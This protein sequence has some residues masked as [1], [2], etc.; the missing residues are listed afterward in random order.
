MSCHIQRVAKGR[1]S[2]CLLVLVCSIGSS[3]S[4]N[5]SLGEDNDVEVS[6]PDMLGV[7]WS[8]VFIPV[9]VPSLTALEVSSI[10]T[11]V[12]FS[13][14]VLQA[15][16]IAITPNTLV[17]P[18]VFTVNTTVSG[19]LEVGVARPDDFL[20]QGTLFYMTFY[21][22]GRPAATTTI[23]FECFMFNE[24]VPNAAL[25]DGRFTVYQVLINE[26]LAD[27]P[28]SRFSDTIG[29]A[30]RDGIRD[31]YQDEFVEIVNVSSDTVDIGGWVIDD[32]DTIGGRFVFPDETRIAP[33]E[34]VVL[35]GGSDSPSTIYSRFLGIQVFLDDGHIGDG[36]ENGD[37]VYLMTAS[38]DT[39][40]AVSSDIWDT[41]AQSITRV[42]EPGG[43]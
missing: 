31:S 6:I 24:G 23:H 30:N 15:L 40:D 20:G 3:I 2:R 33:R 13:D 34:Y 39:A 42:P 37:T 21:V 25:R 16:G 10:Y 19:R 18:G 43:P 14:T 22:V 4:P 9:Q 8:N 28:G 17:T 32:D 29:D 11:V 5:L 1:L 27:P 35:F 12:T 41:I 7:Q 36:L 26:V 38:G